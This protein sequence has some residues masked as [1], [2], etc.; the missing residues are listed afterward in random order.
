MKGSP[1]SRPP[2]DARIDA[3]REKHA[4]L[5]D[6]IR[7]EQSRPRPDELLVRGLKA[8]KLRLKD[9]IEEVRAEAA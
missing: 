6:E 9:I 7:R 4:R 8:N 5:D 3:L 1:A 2:R